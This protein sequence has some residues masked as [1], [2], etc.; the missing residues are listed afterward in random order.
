MSGLA[1]TSNRDL[2]ILG[3]GLMLVTYFLFSLVDVSAKWLV[4]ASV[5][6]LQVAFLRYAGHF[7]ISVGLISR[8][9]I[10]LNRF[11]TEQPFLVILRAA[12]LMIA[13]IFNFFSVKYIPL[14]LTSTILFSSPIIIC[15]LSWP[16]LGERVGLWRWAAIMLGFIGVLIAIR[17]FDES[18]HW[19]AL[20]SLAGAFCFALY[21]IITRKLSGVVAVD[22]LQFYSGFVGTI[23]LLPFALFNWTN[24]TN[25]IELSMMIGIGVF[26]WAGHELLT[27]AHGFA[28]AST[29]MPFG[30][31]FIIYLTIWSMLIFGHIPDIWTITGAVIIIISS[32]IIWARERHKIKHQAVILDQS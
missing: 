15:M 6:A 8:G 23:T 3:M 19:A 1:P 10:T 26:A 21:S 27:R 31:S 28:P 12:L 24:P 9:G 20:L 2:P 16:L 17:P 32:M 4:L 18:F 30:Y 5:P 7:V 11:S 29:L 13:T 22:T 14:T 25:M